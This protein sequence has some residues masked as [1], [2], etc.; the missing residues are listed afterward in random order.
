M[1]LIDTAP[2]YE[3]GYSEEIVGAALKGC[4]DG[5]FVIDKI[6]HALNPVVPQVEASLKALGIDHT[7]LF[8]FHGLSEMEKWQEIA[9]PGGGLD[10]LKDCITAGKR[11]S[12]GFQVTTPWS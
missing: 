6:D 3:D 5:M 1:N 10:Q 7:D 9:A 11:G 12:W 4:R 8:V 2:A